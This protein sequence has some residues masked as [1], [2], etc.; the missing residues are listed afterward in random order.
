MEAVLWLI[1]RVYFILTYPVEKW[2]LLELPI[3]QQLKLKQS[4]YR[5]TSVTV[6]CE[7]ILIDEQFHQKFSRAVQLAFS[8]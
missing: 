4:R 6:S 3:R 7:D 1:K 8:T 5:R 2:V